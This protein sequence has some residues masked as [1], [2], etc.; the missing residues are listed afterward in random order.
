[1]SRKASCSRKPKL[2]SVEPLP[3]LETIGCGTVTGVGRTR[4]RERV[5]RCTRDHPLRRGFARSV[6]SGDLL[7]RSCGSRVAAPAL[8]RLKF[9]GNDLAS[10]RLNLFSTQSKERFRWRARRTQPVPWFFARVPATGPSPIFE[11][12]SAFPPFRP[13]AIPLS[14]SDSATRR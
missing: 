1:M 9:F 7:S 8:K 10:P 4:R 14:L 12:I 2:L 6:F 5:E 11:A 13:V 3:G